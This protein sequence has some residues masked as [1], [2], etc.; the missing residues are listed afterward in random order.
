[1][2]PATDM[3]HMAPV[4]AERAAE[5]TARTVERI[6]RGMGKGKSFDGF[7]QLEVVLRPPIYFCIKV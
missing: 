5:I 7:C 2:A 1:M 4:T 6:Q 3:R